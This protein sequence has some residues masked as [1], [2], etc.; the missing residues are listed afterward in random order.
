[1]IEELIS[2]VFYA[3]NVAHFEHWRAKGD[4]SYAKHK[5]LGKFYDGVIDAID[6][7][8]EAYQGAFSLIGNIPAPSVTER[9]VLKLLEA[10]AE[11][12]E[13]NHEAVCKGNRAVA[14]LIDGVTEVYL[15]TVYKL[16]N[17][18]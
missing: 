1:M 17:L 6:R 16:R 2:R 8:V 13:E 7:L 3:R 15:T 11:W 9:D 4:G 18:K 5:A 14:N 10:D 12:I